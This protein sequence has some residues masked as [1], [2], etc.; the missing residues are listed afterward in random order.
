LAG[1][2]RGEAPIEPQGI[3]QGTRAK[4]NGLAAAFTPPRA[5]R[6]VASRAALLSVRQ[7]AE[8]LSV[9]TATIYGLIERGELA[10][11]RVSNAIRIEAIA[12]DSY[13]ATTR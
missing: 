11:V 9:S 5:L 7:V 4:P 8:Q 12:I 10:H 13:L 6:P 3:A 2:R 1:F